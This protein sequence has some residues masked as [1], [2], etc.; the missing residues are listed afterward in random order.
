MILKLL[1][2]IIKFETCIRIVVLYFCMLLKYSKQ[3][4]LQQTFIMSRFLF[5]SELFKTKR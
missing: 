1:L 4:T 3:M 2:S 5:T